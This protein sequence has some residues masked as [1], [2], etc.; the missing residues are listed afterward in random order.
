MMALDANMQNL[1]ELHR[2]AVSSQGHAIAMLS[3]FCRKPSG[4][5]SLRCRTKQITR[6]EPA[7]QLPPVQSMPRLGK[8]QEQRKRITFWTPVSCC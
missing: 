6:E 1:A 8:R 7:L 5:T 3:F 2:T 4:T